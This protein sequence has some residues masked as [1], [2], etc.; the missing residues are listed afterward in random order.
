MTADE[1]LVLTIGEKNISSWSMRGWLAMHIKE[2][3]FEE[4]TVELRTDKDRN[5]RRQVSPTGRVPVLH[6]GDRV[7]PD[8]LAIIEYLE[9]TFPAPKHP[10]LW[11]LEKSARA[12]ARWLAASMHSGFLKLREGMSFNLCFLPRPPKPP[13][14]ALLEVAEML[15]YFETALEQKRTPGAFLFGAF[16]AV[17][18]M[19]APAVVRLASF[20]VPTQ[21]T[22]QAAAYLQAVLDH[23]P[24]ARWLREARALPPRETY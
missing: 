12:H 7:I 3:S 2:L 9:E 18:A 17:D 5:Q 11:P 21:K 15:G 6:H 19:F 22:P 10:P 23:P 14:D 8:S 4:R 24:V 20:G 13:E 1:K 16:G